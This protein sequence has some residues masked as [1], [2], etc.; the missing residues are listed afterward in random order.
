MD[1]FHHDNDN[2]IMDLEVLLELD[3][4]ELIDLLMDFESDDEG[5]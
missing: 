5:I 2:I 3:D 1:R 4:G